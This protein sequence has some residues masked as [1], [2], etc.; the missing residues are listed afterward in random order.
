MAGGLVRAMIKIKHDI[1]DEE[2][3]FLRVVKEG[4]TDK[5]TFKQETEIKNQGKACSYLGQEHSRKRVGRCLGSG[6]ICSLT[7]LRQMYP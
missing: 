4:P 3:G 1:G 2:E 7:L 6:R 5:V